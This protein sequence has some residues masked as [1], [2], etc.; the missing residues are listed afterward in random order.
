MPK[1]KLPKT[2]KYIISDFD[3]I[4][5]DNCVYIDNNMNMMRKINFKDLIGLSRLKKAGIDVIFISGESNAIIDNLTKRFNLS[6]NHQNIRIKIDVLK[7]IIERYNLKEDEYLY[8]GDDINDRDCLEFAKIKITVPNAVDRIKKIKKIQIT[9]SCGG[10]GA[11]RE[12]ANCL[13]NL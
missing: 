13:L 2:I 10:D 6:E 9:K 11:F 3:G 7:D 5:T 12:V 1:L 4:F 8:M